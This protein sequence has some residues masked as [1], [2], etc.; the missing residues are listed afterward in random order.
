M[1]GVDIDEVKN[2]VVIRRDS[3]KVVVRRRGVGG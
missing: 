3:R 1:F 2:F